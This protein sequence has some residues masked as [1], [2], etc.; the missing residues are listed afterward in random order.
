MLVKRMTWVM[1]PRRLFRVARE[2]SDL[3]R[4]SVLEGEAGFHVV[5]RQVGIRLQELTEVG[6]GRQKSEHEL[7]GDTRAPDDRLPNHHLGVDGDSLQQ[8]TIV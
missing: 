7:D 4:S 5:H 6:L 1:A 8:G 2:R 3:M